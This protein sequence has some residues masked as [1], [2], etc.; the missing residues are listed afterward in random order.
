MDV[1]SPFSASPSGAGLF[2]RDRGALA[3]LRLLP[4]VHYPPA[5][6]L[7]PWSGAGYEARALDARGYRVTVTEAEEPPPA[8]II[9]APGGFLDGA[10][11]GFDLVCETGAFGSLSPNDQAR[12]VDAA[13]AALRIGGLLFGAFPVA[14][15]GAGALI[16]RL[17]PRFDV[18]RLEPSAFAGVDGAAC[19]EA[20]FVRR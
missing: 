20:V 3:V 6:V 19:F 1:S 2:G 8:G 4:Y 14:E 7:V 12:Y 15:G 13:A 17:A 16:A 18:A 9:V 5:R 10:A 11:R